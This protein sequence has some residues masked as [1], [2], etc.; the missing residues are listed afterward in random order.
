LLTL[1]WPLTFSHIDWGDFFFL[2]EQ[3][4]TFDGVFEM[5]PHPMYSVGYFG[6]YGV[7]LMCASYTVLYVS[8]AAHALQ[9]VFLIYVENPRK[10]QTWSITTIR[11]TL[12][13]DGSYRYWKDIQ[14][15]YCA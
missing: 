6:Y 7:S 1:L 4:L 3:S 11:L 13:S 15:S 12:F 14:P 10:W 9:F 2:I 5:A 8:M